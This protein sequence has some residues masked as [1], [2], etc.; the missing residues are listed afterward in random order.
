MS[1]ENSTLLE[2]LCQ[3]NLVILYRR[4]MAPKFRVSSVVISVVC[5]GLSMQLA[6]C[7]VKPLNPNHEDST[8][9]EISDI[10]IRWALDGQPLP[11]ASK[12]KHPHSEG[13]RVNESVKRT[14]VV[15]VLWNS[16]PIGKYIRDSRRI[17]PLTDQDRQS[18]T[19]Q[20]WTDIG[21][22]AGAS[23]SVSVLPR[24][25]FLSRSVS[26]KVKFSYPSSVIFTMKLRKYDD[27][28]YTTIGEV[29]HH[30]PQGCLLLVE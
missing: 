17:V 6:S 24:L 28:A 10:L 8:V 22:W 29:K 20:Q 7:A 30:K 1:T 13:P 4:H 25:P 5:F 19:L 18:L 26:Y 3:T 23:F 2:V 21:H 14:E 12:I 15:Y 11:G 27:G 9:R 16:N